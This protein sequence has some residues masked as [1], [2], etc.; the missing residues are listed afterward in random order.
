MEEILSSI[1]RIIADEEAEGGRSDDD[2]V[3]QLDAATEDGQDEADLAE[4]EDEAEDDVLELTK[5]VRESG[6]V[7]DLRAGDDDPAE[8]AALHGDD[9]AGEP[10]AEEEEEAWPADD[11]VAGSAPDTDDHDERPAAGTVH[12]EVEDETSPAPAATYAPSVAEEDASQEDHT[13]VPKQAVR[14]ELLSDAAASA[15]TGAFAK[16]SH[17]FQRTPVEES[18]ADGDGRSIEQFVEDII[19]PMLRDWLDEKLPPIVERLVEKEIHKIARR[20]ELM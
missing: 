1:R 5:V 15:A 13:T 6:Q 9:D 11:D 10:I 19:R 16:L 17:A 20:A 14:N 8:P 2:E 12:E 3:D 4:P 18:I 7:V